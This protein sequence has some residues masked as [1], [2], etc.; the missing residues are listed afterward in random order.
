MT[1]DRHTPSRRERRSTGPPLRSRA[2]DV[3]GADEGKDSMESNYSISGMTCENC[4]HHVGEALASLDGV[5][6]ATADYRVGEATVVS[7]RPLSDAE[8]SSALEEAGYALA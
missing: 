4:D 2:Y 1:I 8:V 6:S 7:D 3:N 5:T